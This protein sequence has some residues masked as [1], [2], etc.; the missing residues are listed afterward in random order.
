MSTLNGIVPEN[1]IEDMFCLIEA[2]NGEI[3]QTIHLYSHDP[4]RLVEHL[5]HMIS[6]RDFILFQRRPIQFVRTRYMIYLF[7]DCLKSVGGHI[8]PHINSYLMTVLPEMMH[9][10]ELNF[11][12]IRFENDLYIL[13][14]NRMNRIIFYFP[15]NFDLPECSP[16][17]FTSLNLA[18]RTSIQPQP[19]FIDDEF[20]V[21]ATNKCSLF[22]SFTFS[23]PCCHNSIYKYNSVSEKQY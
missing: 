6:I 14:H 19:K 20:H 9:T 1:L 21:K 18:R 7:A 17:L 3:T 5:S 8:T 10:V 11:D 22:M 13:N 4:T 23:C 12:Y 16:S 15:K 2:K